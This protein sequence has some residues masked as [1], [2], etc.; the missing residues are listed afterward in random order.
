MD[1]GVAIGMARVGE[2]EENGSAERLMGTI[3]EEEVDLSE[4][5]DFGDA[6]RGLERFLGEVYNPK[7]IDSSL[8]YLT[9]AEYE[10]A[11]MSNQESQAAVATD[12]Q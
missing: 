12:V 5:E 11:W 1:H 6:L 3:K 7:R 4:Y 2:P 10:R 8:G 9:L